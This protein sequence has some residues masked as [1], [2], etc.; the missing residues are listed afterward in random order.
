MTERLAISSTRLLLVAVEEGLPQHW[1]TN[2]ASQT[3]IDGRTLVQ[4]A[5]EGCTEDF[6]DAIKRACRNDWSGA[7]KLFDLITEDDDAEEMPTLDINFNTETWFVTV[8]NLGISAS[9]PRMDF[10]PQALVIAVLRYYLI[11]LGEDNT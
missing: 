2:Q 9:S 4:N 1:G 3:A 5:F 7:H 6:Y 10:G 11:I 8:K